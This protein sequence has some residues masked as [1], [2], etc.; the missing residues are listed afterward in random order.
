VVVPGHPEQLARA[1]GHLADNAARHARSQVRITVAAADDDST[2]RLVVDDD[3]PGIPPA[4]RERVFERFT[5]L[6]DARTRA[7]GGTGLGLAV[8]RSIV[9]THGGAITATHNPRGG[10][11]FT[12]TLPR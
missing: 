7:T 12:T 10:A 6:D 9:E 4:D 3:G 8:T 2:A 5:R 11:R 1:L